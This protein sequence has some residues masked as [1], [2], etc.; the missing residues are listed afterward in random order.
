MLRR[1]TKQE[2][3][4]PPKK[5]FKLKAAM[6]VYLM[7]LPGLLYMLLNNYVPMFGVVIAFKRLDFGKGLLGSPWCGFENFKFLF[8]SSDAWIITR[9]TIG[10]N[11]IFLIVNNVLAIAMAVLLNEIRNKRTSK[12]Y[13]TLVLLPYLMSW[14]IVSYLAYA[15]LANSTGLINT[16]ILEPMGF[17]AV[18]WYGEKNMWPFILIFFNAWKGVGYSMIIYLSSVVGISREYYEAAALDGAGKWQQITRITLPLLKPTVITL[19]IL[20]IGR[21]LNSD[22]GLFYQLPRNSSLLYSTTRTLDV[23]VYQALMLNNNYGM[24]SAASAFQSI[25]GFILVLFSNQILR[26]YEKSSALF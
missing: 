5:K 11:I 13:Q 12:L 10:Y 15:Y 24:S 6:P 4:K 7:L 3:L 2:L 9:N 17:E 1:K 16:G 22:F 18:N 19:F 20:S 14:V 26:K 21:I 23:Y 25:V 8:G